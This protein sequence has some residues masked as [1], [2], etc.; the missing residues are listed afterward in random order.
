[1]MLEKKTTE[2]LEALASSQPVPGGGGASATVGAL[3]SALV[4]LEHWHPHWV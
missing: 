3:A 4:Q 2:F 1:M